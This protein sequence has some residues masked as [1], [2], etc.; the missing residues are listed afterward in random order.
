MRTYTVRPGDSPASIASRDEHASC[1]KCAKDLILANGHKETVVH[2][3]G[4]IS[5]KEL[6]VGE[7]LNLPEKWFDPGFDLLPPA[8]FASLPYADG[9][10]PSPF[11]EDAPGILRDFRALDV[12]AEKLRALTAMENQAFAKNVSDVAEAIDAAVEP[13]LHSAIEM[14]ARQAFS[15]KE[16]VRAAIPSSK[17]FTAFLSTGISTAKA[18]ADVLQALTAAL[19]NARYAL[20]ERYGAVQPPS[21]GGPRD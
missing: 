14:A 8:Y 16:A 15:A 19:S 17:M 13:A 4:F 7:V 3:N 12:A 9:V 10:T 21:S 5:F 18:R 2:P 20:K 11:G 6:R 1:P